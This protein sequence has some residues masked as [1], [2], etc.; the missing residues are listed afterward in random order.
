[1][2]PLLDASP[3][4]EELESLSI[5]H[6][7][8]P[9]VDIEVFGTPIQFEIDAAD[10]LDRV[11]RIQKKEPVSKKTVAMRAGNIGDVV[12]T[13]EVD[14]RAFA[15]RHFATKWGPR[16]FLLCSRTAYDDY[17]KSAQDFFHT[18]STFSVLDNSL[19]LFAENVKYAE[20]TAPIMWRIPMP[21]SWLCKRE[22]ATDRVSSFQA[23]Q[24]VPKVSKGDPGYGVLSFAIVDRP[25]ASNY[26]SVANAYL[27]ALAENGVE[28]VH[29]DFV[30]DAVSDPWEGAWFLQTEAKTGSG[31]GDVRC[32]VLLHD[33]VW[34]IAGVLGPGREQ[35]SLAWMR[36]KRVLDIA[37]R[38][39]ELGE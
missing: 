37:S 18:M 28:L 25:V 26:Q 15:G 11:L 19:G 12:A 9:A 8:E 20:G 10:W 33:K 34:V 4:R 38:A 1:M 21:L 23:M 2:G 36:N 5:F 24:M 17:N 22:P 13:W 39:L 16:L 14:G 30:G 7:E 3:K 6:R 31:V 32:R 35:D 27:E 29:T